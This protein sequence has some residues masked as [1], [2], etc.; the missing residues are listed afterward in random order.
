VRQSLRDRAW[1]L[2]HAPDL[3]KPIEI[4]LPFTTTVRRSRFVFRRTDALRPARRRTNIAKH[5]SLRMEELTAR[6]PLNP[7]GPSRV[8]SFITMR[9]QTT[10][11]WRDAVVASAIAESATVE[12]KRAFVSLLRSGIGMDS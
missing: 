2:E 4:L 10:T 12:S 3:V 11:R 1:L 6:V 9:R 5:Q 7:I 8:G